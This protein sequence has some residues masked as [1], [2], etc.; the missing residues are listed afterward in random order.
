MRL[1]STFGSACNLSR[2][3]ALLGFGGVAVETL[4]SDVKYGWRLIVKNPFFSLTVVVVLGLGI[5][6]NAAIFSVINAVLIK[7]LPYQDSE[8]LVMLWQRWPGIGMPKDQNYTS[9]PEFLDVRRYSSA[10][11]DV[12]A[13]RSAGL[14]IRVGDTPELIPSQLVSANFFELLGEE[15]QLGRTFLPEEE[16]LG[17]DTVLVLSHGLWQRR[18][19][20]DPGIVG[21]AISAN[22]RSYTVIGVAPPDF[23][24]PWVPTAEMWTP[25]AFTEQQL[26]QRG[27]HGLSVVARIR[28]SL[29][30]EQARADMD[31]VTAQI[32][33][34]NAFYRTFD[35]KVL[36]NPLLDEYVGDIRPALLLLMGSVGLVLLIACTN[37]AN[38]L[39]VRAS[40]R[41]REIGIR[42]ALGAG[43]RRL[44]R[45]MLTE[46]ML[47]VA[48]GTVAGVVLA[49][50][51][52]FML[53]VAAKQT[54]PR[55]AD[56]SLDLSTL[57]FTAVIAT[58]T[59]AVFALIPAV[60]GSRGVSAESLKGGGRG[61]TTGG[62]KLRLRRALV[63]AEVALSL[64]LLVG[65]GL[66]IKSFMRLQQVD[67]GFDPDGVLTMQIA[68]P[69]ARYTQPEQIRNFYRELMSR[70]AVVPGV[71]E[72]GAVSV[73]PLSG[74]GSS[75]TVT[76]DNPAEGSEPGPEADQRIATPGY[77][78]AMGIRV[79]RGR[80]FDE[81]D[82][83]TAAPAAII[84]ESLAQKFWPGEDPLGRRIKRGPPQSTNPW[85]TIIGVVRHVRDRTLEEPSRVQVYWPHAQVPL[86]FMGLT[87]KSNLQPLSLAKTIQSEVASLD[88]DQPV[89]SIRTMEELTATS[90]LRR[91]LIMSLLTSF[92]TIA[93]VLAAV[94]IYGVISYWVTQRSQEIGIRMALGAHRFDVLKLVIGQSMPVL[95]LGVLLGLGGAFALSRL[96]GG[97]LYEITTTDPG[98]FVAYSAG[99]AL[100]GLIAS[101]VPAR[102]ATQVNPITA[103]RDQ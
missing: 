30:L 38:L 95:L 97:L 82:N 33:E 15:A 91:R 70:V 83:E 37:V 94:G 74:G 51:G 36:I 56:A 99:L 60:Q 28:P 78:E 41:E 2:R 1:V 42:A 93:L 87:V 84:D 21:R 17:R 77:F 81:T 53:N 46:G 58:A 89:F 14:N 55:L 4:I 96:M 59:G 66:L 63:T 5:G 10:F 32:K 39:L 24:D 29:T 3:S 45:Q 49:R 65:A 72:A 61:S 22:G 25:L 19:G 8:Q 35:Y 76:L 100:V 57:A 52:V 44:V 7:P 62:R 12:A 67:G 11:S 102:R 85:T 20:A 68:L 27:S 75:G 88:P 16:Q 64:L 34:E 92:A 48:A 79:V 73:L 50:A 18:F 31:R 13:M 43:R 23:R 9:A 6:A 54:F 69:S 80:T 40:A 101:Y 98:T 86:N 90:V 71:S 26:T 47:L 103:L